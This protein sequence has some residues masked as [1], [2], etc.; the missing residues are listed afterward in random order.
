MTWKV[1]PRNIE[2]LFDADAYFRE[3]NGFKEEDSDFA[4]EMR[5]EQLI[6]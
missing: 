5:I 2:V 3:Y 1:F 4:K 6:S